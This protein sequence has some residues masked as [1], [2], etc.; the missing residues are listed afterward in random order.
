[1]ANSLGEGNTPLV[2]LERNA[3]ELGLRSLWAKLE[4]MAPTGSFKDR[5]SAVLVTMGR[6]LGVTEFVE[7][8][9][10]NAG[11]SLSAYATAAGIKAHVF[12]PANAA[13]GK[14]NQIKVFGAT[15]HKIEGPRQAATEAA[16]TFVAKRELV[17]MSHNLS[18]YF[19]EGMKTASYELVQMLGEEVEH[20]VLPVGNGSLLIGMAR[21]YQE[22][23]EA[24]TIERIP[25]FHGVQAHAVRPVVAALNGEN[26]SHKD[27]QPT[28][29]SGIAV[30]KPPRLAEMIAC[31]HATEGAGVTISE[32]SLTT[33]QKRLASSEGIFAEMT[34]AGALAGLEK[35][36]KSGA[37]ERGATVCVPITG[38]GLKEPL[39]WAKSA[40]LPTITATRELPRSVPLGRRFPTPQRN[41]ASS[42]IARRTLEAG[43]HTKKARRLR[44]QTTTGCPI[45]GR[46]PMAWIPMMRAIAA[47]R[48]RAA[49]RGL[50]S[51][52]TRSYLSPTIGSDVTS[53]EIRT[54]TNSSANGR[55]GVSSHSPLRSSNTN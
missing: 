51:T 35:L 5:G 22:L 21:G 8:S 26:W 11:A 28:R 19:S 29:A 13:S 32:D 38:S 49:T 4:F 34:S 36:I 17:Y 16:E 42:T 24:G 33:W 47:K 2:S 43:S 6:E 39:S 52:L 46:L 9:S 40:R 15:L 50:N 44:T 41:I 10:G 31:I 23:L 3:E 54:T 7:D 37:I 20:V 12:A 25:R 14:L 18:P 48:P 1:M 53:S 45:R 30:S 27:I 55:T